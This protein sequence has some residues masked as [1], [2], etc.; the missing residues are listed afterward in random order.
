[1]KSTL[2]SIC[3]S[4]FALQISIGQTNKKLNES[5]PIQTMLQFDT[6]LPKVDAIAQLKA[7]GKLD[8][9]NRY[10]PTYSNVDESGKKHEHF[11][12]YY[13]GI[14]VEFGVII[15]HSLNDE[16]F[17][18]NGE[19][20]NAASVNSNPS[21]TNIEALNKIIESKPGVIYL[22]DAPQ[23]ALAMNYSKPSGELLFLPNI[24]TGNVN[25]A[26]KF[27]IYTTQPLVREEIYVDAH[28]GTILYK[29]PIIK[30]AKSVNNEA[31][32]AVSVDGTANTKYS[33]T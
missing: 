4:L 3:F 13:K 24:K 30:H 5:E 14:K 31:Q 32:I 27:D 12:Q 6:P 8:K 22:W 25:L 1:M 7:K 18:I 21:I 23:D 2:L 11:Q 10:V 19:V 17:L 9:Q 28:N 20:Y 33:G 26:Y 15:T 16:V 29:N